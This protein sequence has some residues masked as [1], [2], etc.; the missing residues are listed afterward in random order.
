MRSKRRLMWRIHHDTR[1]KKIPI[2][3]SNKIFPKF[4]TLIGF[5]A[6]CVCYVYVA[7]SIHV[8]IHS[9][10]M[11]IHVWLFLSFICCCCCCCHVFS[12]ERR[13]FRFVTPTS[14]SYIQLKQYWLVVLR[15]WRYAHV[16]NVIIWLKLHSIQFKLLLDQTTI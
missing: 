12:L 15:R 8:V 5:S 6:I 16:E 9:I 13:V 14:A 3:F 4:A 7:K 2:F 1:Q 11:V 10:Y